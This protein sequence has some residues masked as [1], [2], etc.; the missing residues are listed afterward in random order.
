MAVTATE[1]PASA[2]LDHPSDLADLEADQQHQRDITV[3]DR[4]HEQQLEEE[5]QRGRA[6]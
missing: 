2:G 1:S 3:I 5:Q 6:A 4:V